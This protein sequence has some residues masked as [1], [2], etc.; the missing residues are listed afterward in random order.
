ML[1]E[2]QGGPAGGSRPAPAQSMAWEASVKMLAM[3]T[4]I[5]L[6][7][8]LAAANFPLNAADIADTVAAS[9]DL[10]T[11][12]K[13]IAAAGVEDTLK[14]PGPYTLFAPTEEAFQRLPQNT[15]ERLMKPEN[16]EVLARIILYHVVPGK[17]TSTDLIGK[18]FKVKTLNGKEILVDADEKDEPI[19]INNDNNP[20]TKTDIAADN[21][22]IHYISRVLLP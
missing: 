10:A 3:R 16:K 6:A 17:L 9:P 19:R 7:L 14:G 2:R 11:F 15:Q 4:T 1:N 22:V 5:A 13:W 18:M 20:V 12:A 21:G 8:L